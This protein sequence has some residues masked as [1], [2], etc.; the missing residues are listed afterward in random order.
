MFG[1]S[2]SQWLILLLISAVAVTTAVHALLFKRDPRS[3]F[4]WV[5]ICLLFPIAGPVLYAFF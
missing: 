4:A 2:A 5:A 1:M 3:A